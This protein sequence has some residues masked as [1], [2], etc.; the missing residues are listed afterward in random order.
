MQHVCILQQVKREINRKT[1][2]KVKNKTGMVKNNKTGHLN[3]T[4]IM[5]V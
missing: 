1:K 4:S 5:L 3:M 2:T